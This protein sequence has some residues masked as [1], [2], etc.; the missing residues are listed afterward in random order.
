MIFRFGQRVDFTI[1]IGST[2]WTKSEHLTPVEQMMNT[3]WKGSAINYSAVL[4]QFDIEKMDW[5]PAN[6]NIS[7][8]VD[9][10][11]KNL[12]VQLIPFPKEGEIP[13][14][15]AVDKE[16]NWMVERHSVPDS[17]ISND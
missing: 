12:G 2:T 11:G 15:I 17:W 6:N 5:D 1:S 8:T 10:R 13:M 4:N 7:V 3:G 14:I 16:V 9:G